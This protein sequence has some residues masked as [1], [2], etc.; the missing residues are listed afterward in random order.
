MNLFLSWLDE[1]QRRWYAALE[2]QKLG[3]G[4]RKQMSIITGMNVNIIRKG[5]REME[6]DLSN[7]SLTVCGLE[8]WSQTG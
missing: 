8:G 7:R 4:G 2:A 5:Q 3:H 6:A 1:Q